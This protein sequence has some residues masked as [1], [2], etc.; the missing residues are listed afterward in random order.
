MILLVRALTAASLEFAEIEF[1]SVSVAGAVI[2]VLKPSYLPSKSEICSFILPFSIG[3]YVPPVAFSFR[4]IMSFIF[5]NSA[6]VLK[7]FSLASNAW[8]VAASPVA[9]SI[10]R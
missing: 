8:S 2:A 1:I 10:E 9:F 4:A 5:L 7:A 6:Y 3:S